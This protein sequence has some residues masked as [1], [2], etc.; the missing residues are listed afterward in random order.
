MIGLLKY[1]CRESKRKLPV[2]P[3]PKG[4][5]SE[6]VPSSSIEFTNYIVHDIID[7]K[8][9][10][11]CGKFKEYLS[12]TPAQKFSIGKHVAENGVTAAIRYYAKAFH[13]LY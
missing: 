8:T 3:D 5:L 6:K 11:P 7:E 4:S 13:H 1:F 2:L 10:P 9:L 12:L